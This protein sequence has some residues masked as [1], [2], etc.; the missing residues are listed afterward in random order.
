MRI[1]RHMAL[2]S[3]GCMQAC[4]Q[5]GGCQGSCS[6][7]IGLHITLAPLFP[8]CTQTVTS[9]PTMSLVRFL[10]FGLMAVPSTS[11]PYAVC[12]IPY[13]LCGMSSGYS[14]AFLVAVLRRPTHMLHCSVFGMHDY[15]ACSQCSKPPS[16]HVVNAVPSVA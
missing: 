5:T 9:K 1:G 8:G 12:C 14:S 10:M 6:M 11:H 7:Q 16:P 4:G 3:K 2:H 13:G 15:F